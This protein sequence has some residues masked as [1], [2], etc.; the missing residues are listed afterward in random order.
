[1]LIVPEAQALHALGPK[2][3]E[4]AVDALRGL[5][6]E[7]VTAVAQAEDGELRVLKPSKDM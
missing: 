1:M 4:G 2:A 5:V 7:D 6:E 3:L